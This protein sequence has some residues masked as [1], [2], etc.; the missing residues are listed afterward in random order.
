M[1]VTGPVRQLPLSPYYP[2]YPGS[3]SPTPCLRDL[4]VRRRRVRASYDF[5]YP[6]LITTRYTATLL[7]PPT[8][9]VPPAPLCSCRAI[10]CP[11]CCLFPDDPRASCCTTSL[12][13]FGALTSSRFFSRTSAHLKCNLLKQQSRARGV[14]LA[15]RSMA[16]H[17]ALLRR[18]APHSSR[19]VVIAC[20]KTRR[21]RRDMRV[22]LEDVRMCLA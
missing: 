14:S 16:R 19:Q 12:L 20:L 15:R 18:Q 9:F 17:E 2:P 1:P 4:F 5:P 11:R 13:L 8:C 22:G 6:P 7:L 3:P 10:L 21:Q